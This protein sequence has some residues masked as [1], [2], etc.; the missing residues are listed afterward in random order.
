MGD[1]FE[2]LA[3]AIKGLDIPLDG[4]AIVDALAL[5][6]ALMPVLLTS[7]ATSMTPPCGTSTRPPR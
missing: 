3:V 1:M 7:W 2:A 5:L 6:T 4:V